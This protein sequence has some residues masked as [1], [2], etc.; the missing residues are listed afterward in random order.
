MTT[1]ISS[2]SS[3]PVVSLVFTGATMVASLFAPLGWLADRRCR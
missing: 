1:T 2:R 3:L